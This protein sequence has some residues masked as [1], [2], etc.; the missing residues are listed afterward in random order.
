L[1]SPEGLETYL[2][3]I[4][5]IITIVILIFADYPEYSDEYLAL[6]ASIKFEEAE[7]IV[8]KQERD[9]EL[10]N[11]AAMDTDKYGGAAQDGDDDYDD[12]D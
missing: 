1:R 8:K 12:D 9:R 10:G 5:W 2:E 7:K 4:V 11:G 3:P 6:S